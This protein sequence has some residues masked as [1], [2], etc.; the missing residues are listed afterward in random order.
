MIFK[1]PDRG[2]IIV[3]DT[4]WLAE[5]VLFNVLKWFFNPTNAESPEYAPPTMRILVENGITTLETAFNTVGVDNAI[6]EDVTSG[7][8]WDAMCYL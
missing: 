3:I 7:L 8:E 1:N 5:Y 4:L 6:S 2:S